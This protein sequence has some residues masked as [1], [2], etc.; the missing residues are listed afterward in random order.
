MS[1]A[2]K[3]ETVV[4]T[5]QHTHKGEAKV[6]GDKIS[7]TARQKEW[8]IRHKKVAAAVTTQAATTAKAK[9]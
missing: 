2:E 4:L 6:A 5:D 7:V 8:L 9:E 1:N 3:R